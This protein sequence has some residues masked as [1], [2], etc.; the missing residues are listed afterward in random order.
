MSVDRQ[1]SLTLQPQPG[2]AELATQ[3]PF[4]AQLQQLGR[5]AVKDGRKISAGDGK[6]IITLDS[7]TARDQGYSI[8]INNATSFGFNISIPGFGEINQPA[9]QLP[10]TISLEEKTPNTDPDDPYAMFQYRFRLEVND[11][12]MVVAIGA[13]RE[14]WDKIMDTPQNQMPF[15]TGSIPGPGELEYIV[16]NTRPEQIDSQIIEFTNRVTATA[17]QCFSPNPLPPLLHS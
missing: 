2:F 1:K 3:Y 13:T 16:L 14:L 17:I 10:P 12:G 4:I 11:Q 8:T 15:P 9:T 5:L 6:F 7:S